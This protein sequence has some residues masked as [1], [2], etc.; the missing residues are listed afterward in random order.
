MKEK[1]PNIVKETGWFIPKAT[2]ARKFHCF[3]FGVSL[4]GSWSLTHP[5]NIEWGLVERTCKMFDTPFRQKK[6]TRCL[7][8]EKQLNVTVESPVVAP[9]TKA[10]KA[11]IRLL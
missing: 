7:Q 1:A 8:I 9:L 5:Q 6:C 4:C 3:V 11:A 10:D 2:K